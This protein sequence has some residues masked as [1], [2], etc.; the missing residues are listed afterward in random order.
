M[1]LRQGLCSFD[2]VLRSAAD[3][4]VLIFVALGSSLRR[5]LRLLDLHIAVNAAA[6]DA[7]LKLLL[8]FILHRIIRIFII[9]R[10]VSV[11]L[12]SFFPV[13]AAHFALILLDS[14]H[15]TTAA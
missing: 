1:S 10:R 8:Y 4:R 14:A 9:N 2:V 7:L 11:A 12:G 5:W 6:P 3:L 15:V 13:L